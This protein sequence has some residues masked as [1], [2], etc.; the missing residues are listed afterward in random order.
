[1][2]LWQKVIQLAILLTGMPSPT[3]HPPT[4]ILAERPCYTD[5]SCV[6]S[7]LR[8]ERKLVQQK[9]RI[10]QLM[11]KIIKSQFNFFDKF[12]PLYEV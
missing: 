10:A 3:P 11:K 2:H 6:I 5:N 8:N 4:P 7:S 9:I 1:M 12:Y